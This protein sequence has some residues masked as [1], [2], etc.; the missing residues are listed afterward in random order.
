M[1]VKILAS[2]LSVAAL[3]AA[4]D[5]LYWNPTTTKKAAGEGVWGTEANAWAATDAGTTEPVAWSNGSDAYFTLNSGNN[6]ATVYNVSARFVRIA[7][8]KHWF[9]PGTGPLTI[10]AGGISCTKDT[11][12]LSV[13][14]VLSDDQDWYVASTFSNDCVSISGSGRLSKTGSSTLHMAQPNNSV[15]IVL[16]EKSHYFY[17]GGRIASTY[18]IGD[19]PRQWQSD[20]SVELRLFANDDGTTAYAA[21]ALVVGGSGKLVFKTGSDAKQVSLS[22]ASLSRSQYGTLAISTDGT[23]GTRSHVFLDAAPAMAGGILEPWAINGGSVNYLTF[24]NGELKDVT[25]DS[26]WGAD[27]NL[28]FSSAQALDADQSVNAIKI[29]AALTVPEGKTLTIMSGGLMIGANNANVVGGGTISANGGEL[30][31]ALYGDC[32]IDAQIDASSMTVFGGDTKTLT[33]KH[34]PNF[35]VRINNGKVKV[36]IDEDVTASSLPTGSGELI[37]SGDGVL[38]LQNATASVRKFTPPSGGFILEDSQLSLS[39]H[40]TTGSG[41]D[42]VAIEVIN[43]TGTPGG[44]YWDGGRY[45][46]TIGDAATN[47]T[48]L[49]DG[50]GVTGGA[51]VSNMIYNTR[52][53]AIGIGNGASWNSATIRN[54][55]E[56]WDEI[57]VNN[58]N[59]EIGKG[60]G[61]NS[62]RL[63]IVGGEGFVSKLYKGYAGGVGNGSST[64]N[65]AVVDGK[66]FAGSAIWKCS[67]SGLTVGNNGSFGNLL[68][69]V[70]GGR[71]EGP[72]L[73]VGYNACSNVV[74]VS[75]ADSAI[76]GGAGN[77]HLAVGNGGNG[78]YSEGNILVVEDGASVSNFSKWSTIVGGNE[79]NDYYGRSVCNGVAISSGG[80]WSIANTFYI[81]RMKGGTAE[82]P[83]ISMSNYVHVTGK[84]STLTASNQSVL[85]GV[86]MVN[87]G[88]SGRSVGNEL[89]VDDGALASA[90]NIY[91]GRDTTSTAAES[92]AGNRVV[93]RSN[94]CVMASSEISVGLSGDSA[95]VVTNNEILAERGG[96]LAAGS[97]KTVSGNENK[98]TV[99]DGGVMLNFMTD[100]DIVQAEPGSISLSNAV[101]G[102]RVNDCDVNKIS[103]STK[104]NGLKDLAVSGSNGF[105]IDS[106]RNAG[107]GQSYTFGTSDD[108]RHF[109][110]LEMVGGT[111]TYR[112]GSGDTLTIDST[113]SMLCSN[114]TATVSIPAA[115]NGPLTIVDATLALM[116]ET[117][118][119]AGFSLTIG[120]ELEDEKVVV[121]SVS[122][123]ALSAPLPEY[124]VLK[125]R[126]EGGT[127]A[128]WLHRQKPGLYLVVR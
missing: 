25:Y 125:K 117:T 127:Y 2:V 30:V 45:G 52:G 23:F 60:S 86:G 92:V 87:S 120:G 59:N 17:G 103:T 61:A 101:L 64:G 7:S 119:G 91:I 108:P 114:T 39:S 93:V 34:M 9:L 100:P 14:V 110:W 68:E 51:I 32:T 1:K 121:T 19:A 102:F 128:W 35:P 90:K 126:V 109:A 55:G 5:V 50:G 26:G 18:Q 70:G 33:L 76:V 54:G 124:W 46:L 95:A 63:E 78:F 42:N 113:G 83:G 28:K 16:A 104:S 27:K 20:S 106:C 80:T 111:T 53:L 112:G 97:F 37:V 73:T 69:V 96:V 123:L 67:A 66:G 21:D 57:T 6:T 94:G 38:T 72:T 85:I 99:R 122:D 41:N 62:N 107:S 116:A 58:V 47:C 11:Y 3:S 22:A 81:G 98:I 88:Q 24:S 4:G 31:V 89:V 48:L 10:G 71:V 118:L 74:R 77:T 84:D 15:D 82:S 65:V 29:G 44:A 105:R 75:G 79:K 12:F 49:V 43:T 56:V 8:G 13:P 36:E 40:V 115:L